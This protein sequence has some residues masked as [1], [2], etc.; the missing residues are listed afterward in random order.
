MLHLYYTCTCIYCTQDDAV[1]RSVRSILDYMKPPAIPSV[2][3]L[4]ITITND[5]EVMF[6]HLS[7]ILFTGGLLQ[8]MVVYLPLADGMHPTAMHSS[9]L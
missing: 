7:V 4:L 6:L 5:G 9:H 1:R 3:I 8:C 2:S